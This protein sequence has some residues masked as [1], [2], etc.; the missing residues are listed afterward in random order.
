M[1]D[2]G[3]ITGVVLGPATTDARDLADARWC[4]RQDVTATPWTGADLPPAHRRGGRQRGPTGPIWPCSGVG[5]PDPGPYLADRGLRGTGWAAHWQA[6][7]G[8]EV[9]THASYAGPPAAADR[10]WQAAARQVV[11]TVTAHLE[12]D[13]ARAFPGAKTRWGLLVRVA[14]KLLACNLGRWLNR[15]FDRPAF[16]FATR[17]SW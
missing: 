14:A 11:A 3:V 15:L 8:V 16:A 12:A 5:R 17:F 2:A 6:D 9:L 13:F 7:S 1:T 10:R 4:G